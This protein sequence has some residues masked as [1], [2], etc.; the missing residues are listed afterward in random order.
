M[1]QVMSKTDAERP[2]DQVR[3]SSGSIAY[4]VFDLDT[5]PHVSRSAEDLMIAQMLRSR[6]ST[7]FMTFDS[8]SSTLPSKEKEISVV[9]AKTNVNDDIKKKLTT[10][11]R[12][13]QLDDDVKNEAGDLIERLKCSGKIKQ[14]L[15]RHGHAD[16]NTYK[17]DGDM[18]MSL[19]SSLRH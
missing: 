5:I 7:P 2:T 14:I 11:K 9:V 19:I 10:S 4:N 16:G 6:D 3:P 1:R 8:V 18:L 15:R 12:K 17:I 13:I